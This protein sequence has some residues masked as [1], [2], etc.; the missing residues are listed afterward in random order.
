MQLNKHG[1]PNQVFTIVQNKNSS[2]VSRPGA[3]GKFLDYY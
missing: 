1:S 3:R 2:L